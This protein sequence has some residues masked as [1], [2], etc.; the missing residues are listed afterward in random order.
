MNCLVERMKPSEVQNDVQNDAIEENDEK[1]NVELS[2]QDWCMLW[3]KGN[4]A[5]SC[6]ECTISTL[7]KY[8]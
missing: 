8:W 7:D 4:A 2:V 1:G 3:S 6:I 5:H